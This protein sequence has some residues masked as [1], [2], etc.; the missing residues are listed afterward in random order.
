MTDRPNRCVLGECTFEATHAIML[1]VPAKGWPID[2]HRPVE[3]FCGLTLC[4][5]H[6]ARVQRHEFMGDHLKAQVKAAVEARG[7]GPDP[8]FARAWIS[9]I[10]INSKRW[11]HFVKNM[12]HNPA[13][14]RGFVRRRVAR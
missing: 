5:D 8:D 7:P 1:N 14:P 11:R 3:V 9:A 10:P 6:A 4:R 12:T 13:P 2:I